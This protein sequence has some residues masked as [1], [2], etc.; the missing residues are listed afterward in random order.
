MIPKFSDNV[1][2]QISNLYGWV[3][4]KSLDPKIIDP[5]LSRLNN[6]TAPNQPSLLSVQ[7]N[8]FN[9]H[10]DIA[11]ELKEAT[12]ATIAIFDTFGKKIVEQKRDW[13]NLHRA[14]KDYVDNRLMGYV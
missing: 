2:F 12:M 11:F 13:V 6:G 10:T 9:N 5:R 1:Y 14:L 7:P 3:G 8:P 4:H